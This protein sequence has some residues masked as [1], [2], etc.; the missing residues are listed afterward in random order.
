MIERRNFL[1]LS[2][3]FLAL[4][5]TGLSG[6][7]A[8]A[9]TNTDNPFDFE[10]LRQRAERLA[11]KAYRPIPTPAADAV[12]AIDYDV[13]QKIKFNPDHALWGGGERPYPVQ[14]FHLHRFA[15]HPVK[16]NVVS[17]GEA[18]PLD[19]AESMFDYE[20]PKA[21][22]DLPS[23]LGFAGF[24]ILDGPDKPTDWLAF[25][26]ASYFRSSGQSGQYGLSARGIAL[27]T[28]IDSKEE[29]PSFTEFWLE[30]PESGEH[31][32]KIYALLDG[33][34]VA[35]AYLFEVSKDDGVTMDVRAELFFRENVA[36]LGIA[37]LTSMYW[38]GENDRRQA[39]DW[40]PEVHDSDGLALWTGTGERIFR[41]IGN[42]PT[43]QISSFVDENPKGFGL[44]QRDRDF[45]NYQDD[46]AFYEARPSVWIEP[47]GTWGKGSVQL[48]EIPTNDEIYDNIVA[49]WRPERDVDQNDHLSLG[50]RLH[51]R[52]LQPYQPENIASVMATRTGRAGVPGQERPT[53]AGNRKFVIDF[54]G[55]PLSK[56]AARYDVT[57]VV[58]LSRGE[59]INPFVVKVVGTDIWRATFD[60]A[61]DGNEPLD[62][63]C[64]LKLSDETLSET[65]L[66]KYYPPTE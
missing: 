64:Y 20:D 59:V 11:S 27:N 4:G 57:P 50:Y 56:M 41:P 29:F 9:Q 5:F 52:D 1:K 10:T 12:A 25:Q 58:S 16:V 3:P 19:Y 23:D 33:P 45:A 40:R 34:S 55:G 66:Y 31:V 49:F 43:L 61:F 2:A 62:L 7:L 39:V 47:H 65:W 44:I 51:W 14:F 36:R 24:R 42:P 22:A 48:V 63:R 26:G 46:G 53:S 37:P 60:V 15:P 32:V 18:R 54:K 13:V 21:V 6:R 17:N 28:A 38:F 30:Q 8:V 35:G